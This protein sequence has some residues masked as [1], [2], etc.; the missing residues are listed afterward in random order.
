MIS[1]VAQRQ[2]ELAD[3]SRGQKPYMFGTFRNILKGQ[4]ETGKGMIENL[5]R[6]WQ[7]EQKLTAKYYGGNTDVGGITVNVPGSTPAGTG[8]DWRHIVRSHIIP[9]LQTAGVI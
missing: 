6:Q 4:I 9:E 1:Y 2:T 3:V 5:V 7:A 8:Q